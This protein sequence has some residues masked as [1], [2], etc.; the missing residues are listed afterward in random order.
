MERTQATS[1]LKVGSGPEIR[2]KRCRWWAVDEVGAFGDCRK[3]T[4]G[5]DLKEGMARWPV[6][7]KWH[8]CGEWERKEKE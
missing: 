5:W 8:W 7:A 3:R 1:G 6:T 2:C 4:P